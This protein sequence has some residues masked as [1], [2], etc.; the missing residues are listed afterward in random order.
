MFKTMQLSSTDRKHPI[1]TENKQLLSGLPEIWGG[2]EC[3]I[4]RVGDNFR[5]QFEYAGHY[6]RPDD[7]EKI[8]GLG[9]KKIRYPVLWEKHMHAKDEEIDWSWT[10]KQ[11]Q[12]IIDLGMEPVVGLVH[13]GSGPSYTDLLD[14]AFPEQ[15]ADFAKQVAKRFPFI[16]YFTPINEP[17]TTARFSGLYGWWYP[18]KKD[19]RSFV[20]ILINQCKATVMAMQAI[21]EVIPDALLVQTEDL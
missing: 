10:E 18:H 6:N 8:S 4:N 5:D 19:Q 3:T 11:L 20:K 16:R 21:R 15:L 12:T 14:P 2:L 1:T 13:H 9:I 7:L 17:L